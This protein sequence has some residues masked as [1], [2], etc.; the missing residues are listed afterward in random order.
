MDGGRVL[1]AA[2]SLKF[3]KSKATEISLTITSI[4]AVIFVIIGLY[5]GWFGLMI[6]GGFLLFITYAQKN[7]QLLK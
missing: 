1:R 7:A 4:F 3:G 5:T 6:V 2:L